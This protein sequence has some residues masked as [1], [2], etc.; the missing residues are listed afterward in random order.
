MERLIVEDSMRG[1]IHAILTEWLENAEAN[2]LEELGKLIE[3]KQRAPL[4]YNHYYTDNVQKARA[5]IEKKKFEA[6]IQ[7][8][9]KMY[10]GDIICVDMNKTIAAMQSK[11]TVDMDEQACNNALI[12]L[13]SFY[14][15]RMGSTL[16]QTYT[17]LIAIL[18]SQ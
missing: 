11:I 17:M 4:T 13:Q 6:E 8:Q 3:D 2:A 9:G 14:K 15:V 7:C 1:Q 18:R 10:K 16:I 12:E 5:D